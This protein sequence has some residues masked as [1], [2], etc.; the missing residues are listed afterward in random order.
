MAKRKTTTPKRVAPIV[1][2]VPL[3]EP[4]LV[5]PDK[6]VEPTPATLPKDPQAFL[7]DDDDVRMLE[8]ADSKIDESDAYGIFKQEEGVIS[9][10][11]TNFID[12]DGK[13][14][15][16]KELRA[17]PPVLTLESSNGDKADF[18]LSK[19]FSASLATILQRVHYGYFGVEKKPRQQ[20]NFASA[21]QAIYNAVGAK[22]LQVGSFLVLAIVVIVGL[23]L[24]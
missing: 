1:E 22:P 8:A 5:V 9:W 24:R 17:N 6:L 3:E 7:D 10:T 12:A 2:T 21:K 13:Q 14:Y 18:V 4:T 15:S 19:D 16:K 23:A 11:I 20:Y